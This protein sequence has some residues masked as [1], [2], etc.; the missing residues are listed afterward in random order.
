MATARCSPDQRDVPVAD[1]Q[2]LLE[3]ML[4][5]GVPVAHA[6][7]GKAKCSTCRVR[8][9][10]GESACSARPADEAEIARRLRFD[11]V[12]RLACR[13][14]ITGDVTVRR[15][16]VD[17]RDESLVS[18]V[19]APAETIAGREARVALLFADVADFTPFAEAVPPYD[20]VHLL[21]RW[22][23]SAAEVVERHGGYVDNYLGDGILAVF[24]LDDEEAGPRA[25]VRAGLELLDEARH[26]ND[27][28]R[29]LY[30]RQFAIRVGVHWGTVVVG[31]VGPA[32][33]KRE[34]VIGDAVNIASRVEG[35]NKACRTKILIT[36][37][38]AEQVRRHFVLG[39]SFDVELKGKGGTYRVWEVLG[40]A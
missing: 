9:E 29:E 8:I 30:G 33:R 4:A 1:G 20:V 12:T 38:V 24:G 26:V 17:A 6:C 31:G 22:F 36:D 14:R 21:N 35:A 3:A 10:G 2:T 18:Q 25:A 7:G 34:T 28:S 23:A 27:Y 19:G 5:A 16:V 39:Q 37:D 11:D 32:G 15:L 13:T 40:K